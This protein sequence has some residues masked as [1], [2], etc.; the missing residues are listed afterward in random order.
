MSTY[1]FQ[2]PIP[3]D[4]GYIG[5]ECNNSECKKYFKIHKD[6]LLFDEMFCPYCGQNFPKEELLTQDQLGYVQEYAIEQL[7]EVA[8]K[9]AQDIFKKG[10]RSSKNVKFKPGRPYKAKPIAPKHQEK[11]VDS[12]VQCSNC[13]VSFQIYGIFSFCPGC[14]TENIQIY[15]AN[16]EI[17]TNEISS[18][19]NRHRSLRHAYSDLISTFEIVAKNRAISFTKDQTNFQDLYNTR[20]FFKQHIGIDVFENIT[21]RDIRSLQRVFQKRHVYEHNDGV[22]GKRYVKKMPEDAHLENQK[23][24]LSIEEFIDGVKILRKVIDNMVGATVS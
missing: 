14:S 19:D 9:Q 12:Q 8:I 10:F 2:V 11:V 15:D 21:E 7:R 18:G 22:I 5:R 13:K 6:S 17:I 3:T 23:A 1:E 20:K 16:L 24:K 4:E